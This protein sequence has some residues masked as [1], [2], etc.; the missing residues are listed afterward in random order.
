[1]KQLPKIMLILTALAFF[2]T[3]PLQNQPACAVVALL[4][5]QN[6]LAGYVFIWDRN[7]ELY[8]AYR[9]ADEWDL[10]NSGVRIIE[11]AA[12]ADALDAPVA[13]PP[14]AVRHQPPV[15]SYTYGPIA[16]GRQDT[17]FD[18]DIHAVVRPSR[19]PGRMP[20]TQCR[21]AQRTAGITCTVVPQPATSVGRF[22]IP[23][24]AAA[25]R[26]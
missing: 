22:T 8:V 7:G 13:Q 3:Q 21:C 2:R 23:A 12:A 14:Y 18:V 26:L 4:A 9:M 24:P 11:S 5:G 6:H 15:R 19:R 1:M 20:H 25:G 16:I 17:D 10:V